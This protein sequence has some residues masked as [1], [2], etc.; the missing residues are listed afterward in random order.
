[1]INSLLVIGT[2]LAFEEVLNDHNTPYELV[3]DEESREFRKVWESADDKDK[4][5]VHRQALPAVKRI[6]EHE[7]YLFE[8]NGNPLRI[9]FNYLTR[10]LHEDS[11]GELLL[12]R[13]DIDWNI[14]ISIKNDARIIAALP[15][16]DRTRNTRDGRVINIFNEIDDFGDRIFNVP[17][18]NDYFNDVNEVLL[19][20]EP[21]KTEEWME[22]IKDEDFLYGKLVSPM[23][24]AIGNEISRIVK[25]HPEAPQ[26]LIDYFYGKYDYYFFNPIEELEV[27][28]IGA[29]NCHGQL[30]RIPDSH[31]Y[32]TPRVKYPSELL[33]VRFATGK[34][35]EI[36]R[37]TIKFAFDGGWE[38]CMTLH[39]EED[40]IDDRNF[41]LNVYLPA[42]PYGSYRDQV[43]WDE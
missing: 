1:M 20:F 41:S 10:K 6:A 18:T 12:E 33:E 4:K 38:L 39:I 35:G 8:D 25:Y 31:H 43:K 16:A 30:G 19:T 24:K 17:C 21:L 36:L 5:L 42:T 27:T 15:V 13:P 3:D 26:K 2:A 11:F 32:Y 23:L 40:H 7:P 37:D 29:V 9:R 28:R 14:S 22:M 34:S